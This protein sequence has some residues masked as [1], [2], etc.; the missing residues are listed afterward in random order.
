ME[1]FYGKKGSQKLIVKYLTPQ[2]TP[3]DPVSFTSKM[4]VGR[5]W[6]CESFQAGGSNGIITYRRYLISNPTT[7]TLESSE[8]ILSLGISLKKES[9]HLEDTNGGSWSVIPFSNKIFTLDKKIIEIDLVPGEFWF[10]DLFVSTRAINDFPIFSKL[11]EKGINPSCF[12]EGGIPINFNAI[13]K[14]ETLFSSAV[15][16]IQLGNSSQ[17][18]LTLS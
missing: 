6:K 17:G 2:S 13:R 11:E 7:F 10:F 9:S 16:E 12:L 15:E 5:G 8:P 18:W 3:S 14:I 1:I 4:D